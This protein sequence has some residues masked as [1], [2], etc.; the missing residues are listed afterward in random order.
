MLTLL[1]YGV[2]RVD[3]RPEVERVRD[4]E[5]ERQLATFMII[6]I[7]IRNFS[8]IHKKFSTYQEMK[9]PQIISLEENRDNK[10]RNII[11]AYI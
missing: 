3:G 2:E 7:K 4:R 1:F 11:N 10:N 8:S 5:R 9:I 6:P